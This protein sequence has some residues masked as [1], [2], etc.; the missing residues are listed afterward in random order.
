MLC[1]CVCARGGGGAILMREARVG[2]CVHA[3][4]GGHKD[5]CWHE[6][7]GSTPIQEHRVWQ[8]LHVLCVR[9]HVCSSSQGQLQPLEQ[10]ARNNWSTFQDHRVFFANSFRRLQPD[11]S[12]HCIHQCPVFALHT[13]IRA[14]V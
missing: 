11:D 12:R 3:G 1:V 5:G 14:Q 4:G 8:G 10:K 6:S 2:P 9:A 7:T 13:H